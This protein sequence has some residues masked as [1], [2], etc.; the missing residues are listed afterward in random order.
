MPS[1]PKIS[2]F[3]NVRNVLSQGYPFVQSILAALPICKEFVISDG[4]SN[5]GT[6]ETLKALKDKY[7]KI[8]LVRL[9]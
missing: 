2:C 7:P 1:K 6:F 8:D 5:D 9:R 3:M 4:Y